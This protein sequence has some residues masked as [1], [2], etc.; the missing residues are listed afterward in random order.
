MRK[1][2]FTIGLFSLLYAT[3]FAQNAVLPRLAVVSFNTNINNEKTKA[4]TITVRNLVESRMVATGKYT[5][6]AR[7]EIDKLLENQRIQVNAISSAENIRKLRLENISYIVTGSLDV[8]GNDYAITVRVLDVST[9]RYSHSDSDIMGSASRELFNGVTALM[10]RFVSGMSADGDRVV[11]RQGYAIGDIGPAGGIIFYDKGSF[12]DGWR[13]LEA[14]PANMEFE[15]PWGAHRKNVA[16]T[17]TEIGSG[18]QNTQLIV[19]FLKA[20]NESG[21]AAQ[22]VRQL[23]INGFTDWFLP[24]IDE[25][26]LMYSNLYQ[27]G[28][29]SFLSG[30]SL[31]SYWA[32]SR[33]DNIRPWEHVFKEGRK[34]IAYDDNPRRV[35]AVRAF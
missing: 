32:S 21:S 19:D 30:S 26:D 28:L 27:K 4:D 15:A 23:N 35:R 10:A 9:G 33:Y 22:R 6:I 16:G 11:Q 25:L 31:D 3:L 29:G 2:V 5:I 8:M 20:N 17:S 24:S 14:A 18:R 7:D 1:I 13:Y 12:S 34:Y